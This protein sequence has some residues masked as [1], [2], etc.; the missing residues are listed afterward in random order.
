M[1]AVIEVAQ[2]SKKP[3]VVCLDSP[4]GTA[5]AEIEALES[6]G[7]PVFPLPERAIGALSALVK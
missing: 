1:R 2:D 5:Y 6:A 7:V 3:I 4:G